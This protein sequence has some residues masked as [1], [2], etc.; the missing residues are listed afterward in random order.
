MLAAG[1]GW[2]SGNPTLGNVGS[3]ASAFV[4]TVQGAASAAVRVAPAWRGVVALEAGGT[5]QELQA[6]AAGRSA[7]GFGGVVLGLGLGL[8]REL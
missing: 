6:Q 3:R 2:A 4:M 5:L 8:A 1:G 7:A